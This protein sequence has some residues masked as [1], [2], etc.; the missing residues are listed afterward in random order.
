MKQI[1]C[2]LWGFI[3]LTPLLSNILDTAEMQRLRDIKQ[4]GATYFV[5]P[6]ATHTRLEHS[7]GVCHLARLLGES[8]QKNQ[9]ELKI[10][11]R[12]IEIW[13]V[14]GLIH[15]IGHG[16]FSHLYDNYVKL[17]DEPEHEE[18]G[19]QIFDNLCKR[20]KNPPYRKKTL[21]KFIVWW[22][23]KVQTFITGNIN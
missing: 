21:K 20:E 13:Q 22:I 6:S 23:Q 7:L 10:T 12:D 14:A 11:Q 5:Y 18:R 4:L 9:P 17:V 16:P 15:D 2:P 3:E 1:F 8:L 19:L